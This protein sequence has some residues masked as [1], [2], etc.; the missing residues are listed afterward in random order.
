MQGDLI[1]Y[2]PNGAIEYR[3]KMIDS[4]EE[5]LAETFYQDGKLNIKVFF[6]KGF[7]VGTSS[8]YYPNGAVKVEIDYLDGMSSALRCYLEQ[9]RQ[10]PCEEGE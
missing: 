1:Y 7:P 2:Y 10:I 5:G 4:V 9:G 3:V 6:E 8:E